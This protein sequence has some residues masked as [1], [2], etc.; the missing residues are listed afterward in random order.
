MHTILNS[1]EESTALTSHQILALFIGRIGLAE[2]HQHHISAWWASWADR[3]A[4]TARFEPRSSGANV[5]GTDVVRLTRKIQ[6]FKPATTQ[7][8][9]AILKLTKTFW[10]ILNLEKQVQFQARDRKPN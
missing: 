9:G 10:T 6:L 3:D 4:D 2:S 1:P 7:T 5:R 8:D